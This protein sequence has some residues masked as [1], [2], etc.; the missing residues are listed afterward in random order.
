MSYILKH[1]STFEKGNEAESKHPKRQISYFVEDSGL[2]EK[3]ESIPL[4]VY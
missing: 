4:E 3:G 2:I 1:L